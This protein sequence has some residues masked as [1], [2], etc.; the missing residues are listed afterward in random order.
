M[1][2]VWR[3]RD[4]ETGTQC[5][6]KLVTDRFALHD[7][8]EREASLLARVE[9]PRVVRHLAHGVEALDRGAGAGATPWIAMEWVD[10]V[11]LEAK[12]GA[13]GV[14]IAETVKLVAALADAL[15]ALHG[16]GIVHRD[17]KPSNVLLRGGDWCSPVLL[18]FGVARTARDTR[19]TR[20]GAVL[21]TAGYMAP[22]QASGGDTDARSDLFALGCVLFECLTGRR[23][24][25]GASPLSVLAK[26]LLEEPPRASRVRPSIPAALD[27]LC[28]RMMAREPAERP[29]SAREVATWLGQHGT[30]AS[31][32]PAPS[33]RPSIVGK[34]E[35]RLHTIVLGRIELAIEASDR[36]IS[37]D[38]VF[39]P[40]EPLREAAA[41][42]DARLVPLDSNVV[43]L[44][45][46]SGSKKAD[47][48]AVA[49]AA[50]L[51]LARRSTAATVAIAT[52]RAESTGRAF[53]GPVIE[54][55][56]KLLSEGRPGWVVVDEPTRDL[57]GDGYC[58]R[59]QEGRLVLDDRPLEVPAR[60][61][62][63]RAAVFVGR[64]RELATLAAFVTDS[65]TEERSAIV[66]VTGPQ[67][68]GKTRLAVELERRLVAAD[69][70]PPVV[71]AQGEYL[72]SRS[73]LATVRD[74]TRA[75]LAGATDMDMDEASRSG[76]RVLAGHA[77]AADSPGAIEA[78]RHDPIAMRTILRRS[79]ESLVA[80]ASRRRPLLLVTDNLQWVDA[81]SVGFI[82]SAAQRTHLMWLALGR[83][84]S[85]VTHAFLA[86]S[87]DA[88][89][90]RLTGLGRR[91]AERLVKSLGGPESSPR[92]TRVL[93]L[94]EGNP[95]FL[96]ELVRSTGR[97]RTDE[98]PSSISAAVEGR[99]ASLDPE[100]RRVLRAASVIGG[101]FSALDVASVT[102]E[103]VESTEASLE[104]LSHAGMIALVRD[105]QESRRFEFRHPLV[106]SATYQT[107]PREDLLAAHFARAEHLVQHHERDA[108]LIA[109]HFARAEQSARSLSFLIRAARDGLDGGSVP[110]A[111]SH[112]E[113][114]IAAGASGEELGHLLAY[115]SYARGLEGDWELASVDA[116]KALT[117]LPRGTTAW[118]RCSASLVFGEVTLGRVEGSLEV[119][120][121]VLTLEIRPE[122]TGPFGRTVTVLLS[123]I[124]IF[125]QHEIVEQLLRALDEAASP[126]E[127]KSFTLWRAI[128]HTLAEHVVQARLAPAL[129]Y[130]RKAQ[131]LM[132]S[133][134][135]PMAIVIG[136]SVVARLLA[137][138]GRYDEGLLELERGHE[139]A[140]RY[141]A[142]YL[143]DWTTLLSAVLVVHA[144]TPEGVG[145][146][147]SPMVEHKNSVLAA[148]ARCTLANRQ[149]ELGASS[150]L[151]AAE[152][153]AL[154]ALE[155]LSIPMVEVATST[156][157]A[158]I[159]WRR[160]QHEL[161][162]SLADHGLSSMR[163]R[164][165]LLH[166]MARLEAVK[167][168]SLAA[169]GDR[170][171]ARSF[172][173][174]ARARLEALDRGL[175]DGASF[176]RTPA[177]RELLA[178]CEQIDRQ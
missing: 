132:E 51:A 175:E 18:D 9:H 35:L 34:A 142:A 69:D 5:A 20:T 10:G 109:E 144:G 27:D 143:C 102:L 148:L 81:A 151:D 30:Y 130:A 47:P 15:E 68:I 36:T 24:Y 104:S 75:L 174:R 49:A 7:R 107:L 16:H 140:Q 73:P 164:G 161:A 60:I 108:A 77:R 25:D 85:L 166:D 96:E 61:G 14:T 88:H 80:A 13:S 12:L 119:L 32:A 53:M 91:A 114:G 43:A 99:L 72:R 70:P 153:D 141:G 157:R 21:G 170:T 87:E 11:D 118:F 8:F 111:I 139:V 59:I 1:G 117:H 4:L 42:H 78:A 93:E 40:F 105:P 31:V 74:L 158:R 26:L 160:G 79:F 169:L 115:R 28:A 167:G 103:S 156:T 45:V 86:G 171:A 124:A 134:D 106:E 92:L 163:T 152:R 121:D 145:D 46:E 178:V 82:T 76:C 58:A 120:R 146:R 63:F 48:V 89:H 110:I 2:E 173:E 90:I 101:R 155:R 95:Y 19:I 62:R 33:S 133:A 129:A 116:S 71:W 56:T 66:I 135:D 83:E 138:T 94:A 50:A 67:G 54:R 38:E 165:G 52:G 128:A 98:L 168:R 23:A 29:A 154:L 39:A 3:G 57:L 150:D 137:D 136:R 176:S 123:A 22:E 172:A 177:G 100:A 149:L 41:E 131:S 65:A 37:A 64:E 44:V 113:R 125:G 97:D 127:E 17:L 112:I 162:L 122:P 84:E 147:L 55:A 126:A 159:A 6:V